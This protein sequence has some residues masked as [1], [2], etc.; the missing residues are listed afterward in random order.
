MIAAV[1]EVVISAS[2]TV[3]MDLKALIALKVSFSL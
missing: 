1:M 2:A 3:L